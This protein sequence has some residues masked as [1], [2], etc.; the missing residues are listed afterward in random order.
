MSPWLDFAIGANLSNNMPWSIP[1]SDDKKISLNDTFWITR[2]HNEDTW[3][4]NT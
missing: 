1:V 2:N 3:F 4:D